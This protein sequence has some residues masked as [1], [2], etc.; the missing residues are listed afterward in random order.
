MKTKYTT[1]HY[2]AGGGPRLDSNFLK[3]DSVML[4]A[5]IWI[6]DVVSLFVSPTRNLK[7]I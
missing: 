3:L 6:N 4:G 7:P 5:H 2:S 1:G